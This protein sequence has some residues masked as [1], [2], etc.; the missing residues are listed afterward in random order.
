LFCRARYRLECRELAG[1]DRDNDGRPAENV[2]A[3][4]WST[5]AVLGKR[6]WSTRVVV[7]MEVGGFDVQS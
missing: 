6:C 4:R 1:S 3:W 5:R 2:R 7:V